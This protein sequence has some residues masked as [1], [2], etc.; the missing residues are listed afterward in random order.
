MLLHSTNDNPLTMLIGTTLRQ[1][2]AQNAETLCGLYLLVYRLLRVCRTHPY[3][4][5]TQR[6]VFLTVSC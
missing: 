4:N 5:R 2:Q 6:P 1:F 3:L